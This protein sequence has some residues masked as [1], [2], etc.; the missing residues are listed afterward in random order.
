M[1]NERETLVAFKQL[2]STLDGFLEGDSTARLLV[3]AQSVNLRCLF[4]EGRKCNRAC[5]NFTQTSSVNLAVSLLAKEAAIRMNIAV[6]ILE[7]L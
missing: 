4:K 7:K 5:E 2:A 3:G 1:K 6:T